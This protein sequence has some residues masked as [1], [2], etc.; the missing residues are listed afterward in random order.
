M[1]LALRLGASEAEAFAT[2]ASE[3]EA[4]LERN[5][6]K[7]GKTHDKVGLGV[8]VFKDHAL[9]FASINT[10]QPSRIEATV[11]SAVR[12]AANS[13]SDPHNV[14]PSPRKIMRLQGLLDPE[15]EAFRA[16]AALTAAVEMLRAAKDYDP[17]VTV[18]NGAVNA[19][20]EHLAVANSNGVAVE[21]RASVFALF[22][23]GMAE[24]DGDVSS[25]DFQFNG[26]HYIKEL[27]PAET[28]VA[29]ARNVVA[30][31]GARKCEAFT[32]TVL[33]TPEAVQELLGEALV[34]V[35]N[36]NNVQKGMSRF[37]G[38]LNQ[39]VASE[40]F[41]LVDDGTWVEG[42]GAFS[43]DREGVP[44]RPLPVIDRGVLTHFLHNSYTAHKD[45]H[46]ST[47]NAVGTARASPTVGPSNFIV[48]PGSRHWGDLQAEIAKGLLVTRFS[49]NVSPVSGDFSGVVKGGTLIQNGQVAYP[50]KETLIAGNI[51]QALHR[52][53]GVSRESKK[54]FHYMLPYL[55]I[56]NVSITGG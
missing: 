39:R 38:L 27:K 54:I 7:L 9:G 10:F 55:R 23:L 40:A 11:A 6:V 1:Q 51:F 16:E 5:D 30:S 29:M 46:E 49:G 48:Q 4:F 14:L 19:T 13:P 21:D 37:A 22:A 18:D 47:G 8:R 45:G 44:H 25:F 20:I 52:V 33:L 53:T 17:R 36:A 2:S 32:G 24:E 31:L 56:E 43:F 3:T 28:G 41:S 15:A 34:F 42:L 50:V 26:S 35:C 12:M